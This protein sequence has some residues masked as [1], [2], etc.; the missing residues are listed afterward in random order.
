M[1]EDTTSGIQAAK[2]A[3]IKE[4]IAIAAIKE[5]RVRLDNQTDPLQSITSFTEILSKVKTVL[6]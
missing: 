4:I 6:V 5:N 3:G 1:F 2:A